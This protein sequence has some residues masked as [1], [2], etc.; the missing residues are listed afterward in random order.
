[1]VALIGFH[2]HLWEDDAAAYDATVGSSTTSDES[3]LYK[4][5]V[6]G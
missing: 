6:D 3:N 1:M 4:H 2:P 5:G